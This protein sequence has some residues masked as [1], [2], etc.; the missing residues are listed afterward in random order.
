M[1]SRH[2]KATI[3][4][5]AVVSMG[6][7]A[8]LHEGL[9]HGV[10]A[11]L[12][13]DVVTQLT[14]NHL[15]NDQPDR[16]VEAG[17]TIVN[18]FTGAIALLLGSRARPNLRY[19]LSLFAAVSLLD[20]A[21]YFLYSGIIGVGDW[22][23]V[24]A[25]LHHQA[26]LR[27]SMSIFGAGFYYLCV[28]WIA[29]SLR[30]FIATRSEFNTVG[31]LP[32]LAA[33]IFYCIAGAFDPLGIKLLFLSTIPAA[34]GGLSGMLWADGL[35]PKA[36][37]AEPLTVE[38]SPMWWWTA[39]IFGLA[40][41]AVLGRGINFQ[42]LMLY[43]DG[44]ITARPACHYFIGGPGVPSDHSLAKTKNVVTPCSWS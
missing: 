43:M 42:P 39:V 36:V 17:G 31:R 34:F 16:F 10:T 21:G 11:W 37:P 26:A 3:I 29:I 2:S 35:L 30:P 23:A 18:V 20:S 44:P 6:L 27:T 12:R 13:G 32:Y 8:L 7:A 41:V 5:M 19:F 14:S 15:S 25:G 9:G 33:C 1:Q 24:V 38:P 22:A 40:F 4:S 28:N